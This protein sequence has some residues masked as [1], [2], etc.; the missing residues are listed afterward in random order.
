MKRTSLLLLVLLLLVACGRAEPEPVTSVPTTTEIKTTTEEKI[1]TITIGKNWD[2]TPSFD[3]A[4]QTKYA[5]WREGYIAVIQARWKDYLRQDPRSPE[6]VFRLEDFNRDGTPE[7]LL[8]LYIIADFIHAEH[9]FTFEGGKVCPTDMSL[10][11]ELD[12]TDDL[13]GS[14]DSDEGIS[15]EAFNRAADALERMRG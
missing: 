13:W 6:I 14:T 11:D 5:N 12:Y 3:D 7:L 15:T 9:L 2:S 4:L 8:K 1:T 10:P